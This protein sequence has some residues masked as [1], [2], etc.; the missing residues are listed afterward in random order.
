MAFNFCTK[1]LELA[2][3]SGLVCAEGEL[4]REHRRF[5][6]G[7][8][9][10]LGMRSGAARAALYERIHHTAKQTALDLGSPD[11]VQVVDPSSELL[12]SLGNT[13]NILIFGVAYEK[14]DPE[15]RRLL[16][17]LDEG[18]KL[19]GVM[20]ALNFLPWLRFLPKYRE[21]ISFIK[22]NQVK[23][24]AIYQ[25]IIDNFI[26]EKKLDTEDEV[27]EIRHFVDAYI[28]EVWSRGAGM[29]GSF[30]TQ[31]LHHVA[32]DLFGAGTET[33]VTSLRWLLLDLAAHQH[34]QDEVYEEILEFASSDG[35]LD[36]AE[37]QSLVY[38]QATLLESQRMH[39]VVTLGV[40]HGATQD[41]DIEGFH[42]AKGTMLIPLLAEVHNDPN[43]WKDPD[44][45][46]PR[47][48]I[49]P[50][51]KQIIRHAAFLPFQTGRRVCPGEDFARLVLLLYVTQILLRYRLVLPK[52]Y[53][54]NA[55]PVKSGQIKTTNNFEASNEKA[56]M[57][58]EGHQNQFEYDAD[59]SMRNEELNPQPN[60]SEDNVVGSSVPQSGESVT[61]R[62]VETNFFCSQPEE[63]KK[64]LEDDPFADPV[65]GFTTAPR[66]YKLVFITRN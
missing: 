26:A 55:C 46:E 7:V 17:L 10:A 9:R 21:M 1:I 4:W 66:P 20:G 45:F 43:Q 16:F 29:E 28:Q 12:H 51:D 37:L 52:D 40:P 36:L 32:A 8:M 63:T 13:M 44:H 18:A 3:G 39:P 6:V 65:S 54:E 31:Q 33:T 56:F 35:S 42:I 48:F 57:V 30:T 25:R 53:H 24:H 11:G 59:I 27:K 62:C 5:T 2:V 41:L 49:N 22:V 34:V 58:K 60:P 61:C 50:S 23:S 47:R 64:M 19:I 14:N 38:T 15:W